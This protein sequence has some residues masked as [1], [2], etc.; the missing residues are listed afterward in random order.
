MLTRIFLIGLSLDHTLLHGSRFITQKWAD[1]RRYRMW[2]VEPSHLLCQVSVNRNAYRIL[3]NFKMVVEYKV[4]PSSHQFLVRV[5][6]NNSSLWY[7]RRQSCA[8]NVSVTQSYPSLLV[9]PEELNGAQR[10]F[11]S[12]RR[13]QCWVE[14]TRH[15]GPEEV[16]QL[17]EITGTN[18]FSM[19]FCC[20]I[21]MFMY[22]MSRHL[23]SPV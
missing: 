7:V 1:I 21:L 20:V 16:G 5:V 18:T 15:Y 23:D 10:P 17:V 22:C 19:S 14:G 9:H 13:E 11:L 2:A 8:E 6:L 12:S 3:M 4:K